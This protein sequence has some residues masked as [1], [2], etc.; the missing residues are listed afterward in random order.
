MKHIKLLVLALMLC[1]GALSSVN[2][3][4]IHNTTLYGGDDEQ[5]VVFYD[6]EQMEVMYEFQSYSWESVI[7]LYDDQDGFVRYNWYTGSGIIYIEYTVSAAGIWTLTS[8]A[9]V[10]FNAASMATANYLFPL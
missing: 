4:V 8:G 5:I 1:F 2:A 6:L 10:G 9:P 7:L 3:A